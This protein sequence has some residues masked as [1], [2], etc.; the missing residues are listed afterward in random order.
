MAKLGVLAKISPVS[1]VAEVINARKKHWNVIN[2]Y[3]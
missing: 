2:P 3:Q 1:L